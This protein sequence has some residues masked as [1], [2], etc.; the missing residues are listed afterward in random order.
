MIKFVK[1]FV[2]SP[3]STGAIA[4]SSSELANKMTEI[5]NLAMAKTVVEFGSGTGVF[6][7]QILQKIGDDTVFFAL[8]INPVFV[9]KTQQRCPEAL[10]YQD[11]ASNVKKYLEE[12]GQ[13][14]CDCIVSGL[15]WTLF[16]EKEQVQLLQ[17]IS[18]SLKPNGTFVSFTYLGG[19]LSPGGRRFKKFLPQ[20]F[21]K[22]SR[23]K[24]V[25]NNL[26]PAF[27]YSC[28]K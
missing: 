25:W 16:S 17:V 5:A 8:E 23:S 7:E 28:T 20:H 9:E 11:W 21:S 22:V 1:E 6:T 12:H 13:E 24:M 10:V 27:V 4:P 14:H 26:P 19:N 15:P 2:L 3:K 18:S